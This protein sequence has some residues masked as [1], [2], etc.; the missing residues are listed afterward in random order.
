MRSLLALTSLRYLANFKTSIGSFLS[1]QREYISDTCLSYPELFNLHSRYIVIVFPYEAISHSILKLFISHRVINHIR[2]KY[3][4]VYYLLLEESRVSLLVCAER[5]TVCI[6]PSNR[7]L[8]LQC[9]TFDGWERRSHLGACDGCT[10]STGG[11]G[12]SRR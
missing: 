12:V 5:W 3:V 7:T 6:Q 11:F 4:A 2:L 1:C 10:C 8:A 9:Q